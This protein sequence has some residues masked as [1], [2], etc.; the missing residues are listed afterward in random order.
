MVHL[1]AAP[2][3][4]SPRSTTIRLAGCARKQFAGMRGAVMGDPCGLLEKVSKSATDPY[5]AA[6]RRQKYGAH[7]CPCCEIVLLPVSGDEIVKAEFHHRHVQQVG[8]FD[9]DALAVL[10][11]KL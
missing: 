8:G 7:S 6:L 1:E 4:A 3:K 11:G 9:R 5:L 2:A 10:P